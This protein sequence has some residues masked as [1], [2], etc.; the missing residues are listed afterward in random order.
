MGR[1]PFQW[2]PAARLLVL[3]AAKAPGGP[4]DRALFAQ[5]ASLPLLLWKTPPGL[6][7]ILAQEGVP[8]ETVKDPHP[9]SFRGRPVRA[10]RRPGGACRLD[11]A[12]A[13]AATTS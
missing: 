4:R 10:F 8:F 2:V 11:P 9:F 13:R 12:A 6:E 5:L 3:W 7:L 1:F